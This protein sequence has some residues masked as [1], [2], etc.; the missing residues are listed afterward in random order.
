MNN[1]KIGHWAFIIGLIVAVISPFVNVPYVSTLLFILGLVVGFLNIQ[2]RES[3]S[4]LVATI[5][6][7]L[8]GVGGLQLGA[9]TATVAAILEGLIALVSPAALVV[10]IK[11]V[12]TVGRG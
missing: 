12:L 11:Q 9:L 3:D 8:T 5:A 10:G 2:E 1:L 4:F 7:L 6:L